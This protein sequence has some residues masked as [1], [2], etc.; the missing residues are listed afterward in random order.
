MAIGE[1]AEACGIP[2]PTAHR[3]LK[4]LSE[5]GY[6][7]RYS[8]RHYAL[9]S[10]LLSLGLTVHALLGAEARTLLLR[11]A[12]ELE[13][14]ATLAV[15][16]GDRAEY[17]AH[18]PSIYTTRTSVELGRRVELH[19]T[20]VGK[21][22]LASLPIQEVRDIVR[23]AGLPRVTE[24]TVASEGELLA[25]LAEIRTRGYAL[26]EEEREMGIRAV[27]VPVPGSLISPMAI[28]IIGP[29]ERLTLDAVQR[30]VPI[31]QA[32]ASEFSQQIELT[33]VNGKDGD[34]R[35]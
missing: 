27:A 22:I 32:A 24:F 16:S 30:A 11:L 4:T 9:G 23:R 34:N 18:V 20:S 3:L 15:L 31:L 10:R 29:L 21:A 8:N 25:Q 33:A 14:T 1:I 12:D 2:L 6:I 28:S 19:N 17:L 7:R 13:Q 35:D 26:A 5:R